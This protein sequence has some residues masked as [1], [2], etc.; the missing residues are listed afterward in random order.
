[1]KKAFYLFIT[2]LAL[3]QCAPKSTGTVGF[4]ANPLADS[5]QVVFIQPEETL[6][7][8]SEFVRELR[9]GQSLLSQ[10]CGYKSLMNYA[11]FTAKQSGANLIQ[12]TEVKHPAMGNGCYHITARLYKNLEEANLVALKSQRLASNKSR[13][14]DGANYAIVHFYRPKSYE[15]A[16]ISYNIKMDNKE[17]VGKAANGAHFEYKITDFGKHKFYG[18]TKKQDFVTL[19]IEKGQEYFVRC[20]VAKSSSIAVPDMYVMEN[21]VGMQEMAE[22]Q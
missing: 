8:K 21:Y 3:C 19:D 17:V 5:I 2:C 15:G 7:D 9:L 11:K 6:P 4:R 22:M 18:K 12:L 1:M 14:P 13:L 16:I 20:G 10:D